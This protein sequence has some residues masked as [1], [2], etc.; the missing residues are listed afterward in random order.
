[1]KMSRLAS[2]ALQ[3]GRK[4][5]SKRRRPIRGM[6]QVTTQLLAPTHH[7]QRLEP[8]GRITMTII[9]GTMV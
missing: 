7:R 6:G 9:T 4:A 3:L 1:M 5:G 2:R 8:R